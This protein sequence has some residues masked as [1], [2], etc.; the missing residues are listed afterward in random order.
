M[1]Y[2]ARPSDGGGLLGRGGQLCLGRLGNHRKKVVKAWRETGR[3]RAG[4]GRI[5][6]GEGGR[7]QDVLG[8]ATG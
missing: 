1:I 8:A 5:S 4:Q 6:W 3:G 7:N 2:E